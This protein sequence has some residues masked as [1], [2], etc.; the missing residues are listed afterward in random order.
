MTPPV[1]KRAYTSTVRQEQAVR[2]RERILDAALALFGTEGYGRTTIKAIAER[3]EVAPDTI[4]A[5]FGSKARVLTALIDRAI[6]PRGET[7]VTDRPQTRAVL[8]ERNPRRQVALFA[9][10]IAAVVGRVRPIYEILRTASAVEPEMAAIHQEMD[11]HRLANLRRFVEALAGHGTL[12][13]DVDTAADTVWALA[14]PDVARM[15]RDGRGWSEE[16]YAGWLEDVL[17]RALL[18]GRPRQRP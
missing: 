8:E 2:T 17:T 4:Y 5:V 6:A 11:R 16:R 14:S 3:A 13:V 9:R 12:R 7:N 10:D 1:K 15:L 18:G